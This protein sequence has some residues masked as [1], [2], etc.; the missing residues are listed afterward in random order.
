[1]GKFD[2]LKKFN[3]AVIVINKEKEVVFK[4]N[5]FKRTFSDFDNLKKFSH[6]LYYNVYPI[7][8][9][10]VSVHSPVVQAFN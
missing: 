4:N 2:I 3:S 6:K 5:L 8:S 1:M 10:N 9:N 7:E